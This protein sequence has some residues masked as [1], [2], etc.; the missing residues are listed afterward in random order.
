MIIIHQAIYGEVQGKTSGHDLLAASDEKNELFRRVSGHT[1]LADRPKGGVLS[2]P[3]VRVFFVEEHFLLIKTFPDKS[4]GLRSGRVFSHALFIPEADIHR[5]QNLVHLFQYFLSGIQKEAKMDSLECPFLQETRV[6]TEAVDR[7][8]ATATYALLENQPFV[9]MGEEGYW[10]WLARIW[11]KIPAKEKRNLKIGAAFG[12][13][14]VKKENLNLLYIPEET[15]TL[16][17]K[18][19]FHVIVTDESQIIESSAVNWLIGDVEKSV[20]FLTL[21][22]DFAPKID[23][24]R[25][26]R[27][28]EDYGNAYLHLDK[29]NELNRLLVLANFLSKV[30][31]S[32]KA[33]I[34]GKKRLMNAIVKAIPNAPI[35]ISIALMY[36]NWN[37]F[38]DAKPSVSAALHDW[39]TNHFFK[40]KLAKECGAVLAKALEAETKNWWVITVLNYTESRLL[41]RKPSDATI[42][43]QWMAAEPKL[44]AQHNS[45]VPG[46]AENELAQT[47]P[48]LETAI[49]EKVLQ[50]AKQKSWLVLH[51]KVAAQIYSGKEA[52]EVQLRIDTNSDH[53]TALQTL[54]ECIKSS[55]FVSVASDH[56]DARL[57][58]I[59]GKLISQNSNLLK[60]IDITSEGW[61]KC[62][63]AA[64]EQGCEVWQGFS[65]PQH[66]LF[67][68]L[69]HMLAGN[70]FNEYLLDV[71]SIGTHSSLKDYPQRASVWFTLPEKARSAFAS[72]T[73]V[74]LIDE[75]ATGK[76][77]YN[78]LEP[79]LKKE[80]QS[81]EVQQRII[82]SKT[83]PLTKK[84]RLFDV[85]PSLR[86]NHALQLIREQQFLPEEAEQFGRIVSEKQWIRTVEYFYD[87]RYQRKDLVPA[88][89]KCSYLLGFWQRLSLATSGLKRDAISPEEWWD[90]FLKTAF[91]LF[92]KGPSENG[93]WVS[94][95][96][97]LSQITTTGTGRE[98][99]CSAV[100]ILRNNEKLMLKNLLSRMR[101]SYSANEVLKK[102]E[103]TL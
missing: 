61:Q 97:D 15:K 103:E 44:I 5:I 48:Q 38:P 12:P 35:N 3:V 49:A 7:R 81:H 29:E 4:P 59:A 1:D 22:D 53:I 8:E 63:R 98:Q 69:D 20:P 21:L 31:P 84:I 27:Q 42:L 83:I 77:N 46:D 32:E 14:Y 64:I 68:I 57:H 80:A 101:D 78:D 10:E 89:I 39:L 47:I 6:K 9:W 43:W 75:L 51:A 94:A 74:E 30:S 60:G 88:L 96:G 55:T 90:E 92:P 62:W 23:S 82:S 73:F 34:K 24:I 56:T 85:L 70:S 19:S 40:G 100:R 66:I 71:I 95:G 37:G 76:L 13:S 17:A 87:N 58:C 79:A 25:T 54:S 102:L 36:Q 45:W 2:G 33:G 41:N 86:E 50:M 52:I 67:K 18:N 65:K 99:W 26:L 91:D 11:P 72:A 28:L 16:W 93:L